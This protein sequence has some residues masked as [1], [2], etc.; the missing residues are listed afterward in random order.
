[1]CWSFAIDTLANCAK[2]ESGGSPM[3]IAVKVDSVSTV[4]FL[5]SIASAMQQENALRGELRVMETDGRV[6]MVVC[7]ESFL[8]YVQ[9]RK[10]KDALLKKIKYHGG[11]IE[12]VR[13]SPK[14]DGLFVPLD[15]YIVNLEL[16]LH[17]QETGVTTPHP[18]FTGEAPVIGSA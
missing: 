6:S 5:P 14:D 12:E 16:R 1:M 9:A 10:F 4:A 2:M 7:D 11:R 3:K 8:S 18:V 13:V 17:L 15:D